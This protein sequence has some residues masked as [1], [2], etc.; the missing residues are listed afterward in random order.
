M[1]SKEIRVP[2]IGGSSDVEVI[3]LCVS[4]GDRLEVDD[5]IVVLESDKASMEVPAPESGTV[6]EVTVAVGDKVDE[7]SLLLL[8]EPEN[9]NDSAAPK[10]SELPRAEGA[11]Q[12]PLAPASDDAAVTAGGVTGSEPVVVPDIGSDSAVVVELSV[13]VGD[14]VSVDDPLIVLESDKATMEV[15]SPIQG[16]VTRIHLAV[17]D[18]VGMGDLILDVETTVEA[19]ATP[20]GAEKTEN[21]SAGEATTIPAAAGAPKSDKPDTRPADLTGS[22]T[23]VHAG[24]A[25]R[26]LAREFGVDLAR[27]KG[28]GPKQRILKED[29]Q[30]FVKAALKSTA[31]EGGAVGSGIPA[32]ALP[33][34]SQFGPVV[35]RPMT[36]IHKL[37]ADSMHRSWL[38]VPHVTQFDEADITDME[39]FRKANKA[40]AEIRGVKLTPIPFL[41]KAC[42]HVLKAMPQFNVSL[43]MDKKEVIEKSYIHIGLAVDTPDGLVVPVIRDVDKKGIWELGSDMAILAKKAQEKKLLPAEMQG[44]CFTISSLG[45]IGG[46]AFTPIVNT[47]EVA[48]LG[49]SKASIKPVWNGSEFAPRLMLPLSLSYDHRAV[50]GADA[51]RFTAMLGSLLGDLR[52]LLL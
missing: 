40:M 18:K 47:P 51:A 17:N 31:V 39:S 23:S 4:V 24:P 41:L 49:V 19:E 42:A 1:S 28:S 30:Q 5:P 46:T 44:G 32:V 37:T 16:T 13:A 3:E 36:R 8:I 14:E 10:V 6:L 35:R 20:V 52:N 2:D 22:D 25:V 43:D 29:V 21:G 7:N 45:G 9:Q 26:R 11:S 48:I 27:V 15:P 34:F 38:N 33:D 50:N 12:E